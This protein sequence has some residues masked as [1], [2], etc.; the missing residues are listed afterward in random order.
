M[1][2]TRGRERTLFYALPKEVHTCS[3]TRCCP[4]SQSFPAHIHP[5]IITLLS[6]KAHTH[7]TR[8]HPAPSRASEQR[9]LAHLLSIS[10]AP[11]M[12]FPSSFCTTPVHLPRHLP[13]VFYTFPR[14]S[15]APLPRISRASSAHT[16][17]HLLR[18]FPASPVQHPLGS[19]T[20]PG[21]ACAHTH[22]HLCTFTRPSRPS[23]LPSPPPLAF[24]TPR[25]SR[26]ALAPGSAC[27]PALLPPCAPFRA[28]VLPLPALSGPHCPRL[29]PAP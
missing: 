19:S 11:P 27:C 25:R 7:S 17:V 1:V 24:T 3:G 18:I 21:Y 29:V 5:G 23:A 14:A 9:P 2:R 13:C 8:Q 15:P 10:H 26:P 20:S 22:A 6:L 28:P 16:P 4:A 12:G